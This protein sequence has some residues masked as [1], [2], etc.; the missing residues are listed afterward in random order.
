M[1]R[2]FVYH[3]TMKFRTSRRRVG[4]GGALWA[5]S[6][7]AGACS[8]GSAQGKTLS[9]DEFIA[10]WCAAYAPCCE[11]AGQPTDGAQCRA[12][13][14]AYLPRQDLDASAADACL[15]E[16]RAK[17]DKCSAEI[18]TPTCSRLFASTSGTQQAGESCDSDSDCALPDVGSAWCESDSLGAAYQCQV[19]LPGMAGSAPCIAT[20][21]GDITVYAYAQAELV[22]SGYICDVASGLFCDESSRACQPLYEVGASCSPNTFCCVASA[23]CDRFE[24]KC[25]A[26]VPTGAFCEDGSC[27]SGDYCDS[28]ARKCTALLPTDAVCTQSAQCLSDR[29]NNGKCE[30][31]SNPALDFL[32]GGG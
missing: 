8:S 2:R 23:Y 4:L 17:P 29:C 19:Q 31:E 24:S 9:A 12:F 27:S 14:G 30:E 32:C 7:F 13:Y 11:A 28:A 25:K 1:G 16:L 20:K 10:A 21:S 22:P 15:D 26:R 18:D 6:A 3:A 5:L